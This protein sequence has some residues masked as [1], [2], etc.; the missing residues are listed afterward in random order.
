MQNQIRIKAIMKI[1]S[2]HIQ[3]EE[4]IHA[5]VDNEDIPENLPKYVY[6]CMFLNSYSS[7]MTRMT[8]HTPFLPSR[9]TSF[10]SLQLIIT[11][12]MSVFQVLFR[13]V[14]FHSFAIYRNLVI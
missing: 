13:L 12:R 10:A 11:A 14:R 3:N 9:H 4:S 2:V 5:S 1:E 6:S 7:V 8:L